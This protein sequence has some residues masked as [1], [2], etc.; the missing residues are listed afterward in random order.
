MGFRIIGTGSGDVICDVDTQEEAARLVELL[1]AAKAVPYDK[2][3]H[4]DLRRVRAAMLEGLGVLR[5]IDDKLA[6]RVRIEGGKGRLWPD[7]EKPVGYGARALR[8]HRDR[9]AAALL[10]LY[11]ARTELRNS[12]GGR[13]ENPKQHIQRIELRGEPRRM[14][15]VVHKSLAARVVKALRAGA[16]L[17]K[18]AALPLFEE[19]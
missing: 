16:S 1:P 12:A 18:I 2:A 15:P 7:E 10:R 14:L 8:N 19:A 6:G 11:V 13:P 17:D 9:L 5:G 3:Y 4:A